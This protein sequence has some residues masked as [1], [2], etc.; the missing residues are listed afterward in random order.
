LWLVGFVCVAI[1]GPSWS[2]WDSISVAASGSIVIGLLAQGYYGSSHAIW[3]LIFVLFVIALRKILESKKSRGLS[4]GALAPILLTVFLLSG[5][6]TLSRYGWMYRNEPLGER[7]AAFAW[8][9]TPGPFLQ[10]SELASDLFDLYRKKGRTAVFPGEEPV[11]FV[12][13]H[14]PK[15]NVSSSD[16]M[17]NPYF[18]NLPSWLKHWRIEFVITRQTMQMPSADLSSQIN[19]I[20]ENGFEIAEVK[21]PFIVLRRKP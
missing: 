17:T 8:V 13:G 19:S 10:E 21:S 18:A 14:A 11:A 1:S 15:G 6:A 9:R 2:I 5:L 3:P 20:L 16:P 12:N 7:S 4:I